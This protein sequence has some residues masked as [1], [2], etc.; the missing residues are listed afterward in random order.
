MKRV[1]IG[2][3]GFGHIG[4]IHTIAYR[5]IPLCFDASEVKPRLRVLL[6][7]R[8][9]T[10]E[11]A[12][13][14][15]AFEVVT[16]DPDEFFGE[17]LDV[18]DIC[19]PNFLH[20][21]QARQA[22]E[23]GAAVYCEKPL[24]DS[25]EGARAMAALAESRD[26]LTHVAFVLRYLPAVRQMKMLVEEDVIGDILHFRSYM[27]HGGYLDPSRPMS[28]RLRHGESGGGAFMDLGIHLVDLVHYVL[29][30]AV[31]VRGAARTFVRERPVAV[32][33]DEREPV[34]VDD[35]ALCSL[36][37]RGG[38][39]GTIEVTR[40]AAG[41]GGATGIELHGRRGSLVFR[42]TDPRRVRWHSLE[43]GR[44]TE[45]GGEGAG[46]PGERPLSQIFPSGKY[47]QGY[48]TD[49]HMAS[50]YDFLLDV[51]EAGQSKPDFQDGLAAQRVA[52]AFYR[53]AAADGSPLDLSE[54]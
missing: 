52:D 54:M 38:A 28:W 30:P 49:I 19:T 29:G 10:V 45:V 8:L 7:H 21:E 39:V 40:M 36:A 1:T 26:A 50:A 12:Q 4:K 47:S 15:A 53:S 16:S 46:L 34:D 17:D 11:D 31:S 33:R 44:W 25:L 13:A 14:T 2:L 27:H 35:W 32:G 48:S 18:V 37:L 23:S 5:S 6:R 20:R 51:V 22:L 42:T 43:T 3:I 9:E 24:S 41:A